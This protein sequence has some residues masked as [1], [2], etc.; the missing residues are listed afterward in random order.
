MRLFAL[1]E[2][3]WVFDR[4]KAGEPIV[5]AEKDADSIAGIRRMPYIPAE[6]TCI[7]IVGDRFSLEIFVNGMALS[8]VVC[9][10]A[11]ADGLELDLDAERC[12]YRRFAVE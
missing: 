5:G 11:D 8:S 1:G 10:P 7:E 9:P 6:E 2:G 4:S 3:E 12:T